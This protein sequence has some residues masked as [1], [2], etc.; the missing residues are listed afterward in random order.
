MVVTPLAEAK[1]SDYIF[2]PNYGMLLMPVATRI[3][4][5][6]NH[7]SVADSNPDGSQLLNCCLTK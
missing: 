7:K 6:I 3:E 4:K 1:K 5:E 2:M